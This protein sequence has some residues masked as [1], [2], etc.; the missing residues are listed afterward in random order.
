L[1]KNSFGLKTRDHP[2]GYVRNGGGTMKLYILSI[3]LCAFAFAAGGCKKKNDTTATGSGSAAPAGSATETG[4]GSATAMSSGSAA[5]TPTTPAGK[6]ELSA[7]TWK[8]QDKPG[9]LDAPLAF[10]R[11]FYS[12]DANGN[13]QMFLI[14]NCAKGPA[15]VCTLLKYDNLQHEELDKVCPGWSMVHIVINPAK[16]QKAGMGPLKLTPGK[17]GTA[18]EPIKL[19]MVEYT[20]KND[21]TPGTVGGQIY[22]KEPNVE[23][24]A[25]GDTIAGTFDSKDGD[26]AFKGSFHA[27]KCVC[28]PNN[29]VCK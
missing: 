7:A 4:S 18:S 23:L 11:Q 26:R 1:A 24:T 14:G 13:L 10:D 12:D 5:A 6:D 2:G 9:K 29:P 22:Q 19:G 15:E 16:D 25:V 3:T 21:G 17:L 20:D 28:D 27:K 8:K